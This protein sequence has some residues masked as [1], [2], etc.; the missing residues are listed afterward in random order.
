[1][2]CGAWGPGVA[3][4]PCHLRGPV[5]LIQAQ[6]PRFAGILGIRGRRHGDRAQTPAAKEEERWAGRGG[7]EG[8]GQG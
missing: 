6:F 1:M 2:D 7:G 4:G 3:V 5:E 8:K